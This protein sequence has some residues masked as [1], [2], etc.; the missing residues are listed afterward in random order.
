MKFVDLHAQFAQLETEMRAAIERV[1]RHGQFIMGPEVFELESALAQYC[2][3][4]H[5]VSAASGTDAL[6]MALMAK[7]VGRGDAIIVPPFTFVA[8]AEVVQLLGA[9]TVFVDVDAETFNLD[10][11]KLEDAIARINSRGECNLRGIIAVDLFGLP[12]DYAAITPVA[13]RHNLFVLSDAAQSFGAERD[14]MRAG[15]CGDIA[16]TSFFPAKPLGAYGDG[17]ALFTNDDA[18]AEL[19]RSI[20]MHGMGADR[21]DNVRTGITGRLDTL[22]AAV[23]LCKLQLFDREIEA[24]RRIAETYTRAL[25]GIV[26]TPRIPAGAKSAW[27]QYTLRSPARDAIC[28]ALRARN[29]PTALYYPRPLHQQRAFATADGAGVEMPVS[30]MLAREVFS[31]PVHPYLNEREQGEVIHAVKDAVRDS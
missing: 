4:K 31:L 26:Q 27:A 5:A 13:A 20:R 10:A 15:A 1:L 11:S 14:G 17:G 28:A 29:I 21:Y 12:A 7:G 23:L 2:G 8:S 25:E 22:Q 16:A 9:T 3:V 19:A 30:E 6:L 18:T 24:R